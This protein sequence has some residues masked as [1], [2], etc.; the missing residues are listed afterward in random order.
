MINTANQR[1]KQETQTAFALQT[2]IYYLQQALELKKRQF[3]AYAQATRKTRQ[4]QIRLV[5]WLAGSALLNLVLI[6]KQ[7]V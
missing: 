2:Q 3:K 4:A 5:L 6:I 7:F 1:V